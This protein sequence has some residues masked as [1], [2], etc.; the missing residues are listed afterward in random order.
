LQAV[1]QVLQ[2]PLP[3]AD[4]AVEITE[5]LPLFRPKLIGPMKKTKFKRSHRTLSNPSVSPFW[6]ALN[7]WLRAGKPERTDDEVEEILVRNCNAC[8]RKND[9]GTCGGCGCRIKG[10]E[11][12]LVPFLAKYDPDNPMRNK[13]R[14]AIEHCPIW[15]W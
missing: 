15:L 12:E 4:H 3:F 14:I 10:N 1:S 13:A 2:R 7:V 8:E 11:S 9:D 5:T 6:A